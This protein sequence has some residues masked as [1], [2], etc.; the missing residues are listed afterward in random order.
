MFS[1]NENLRLESHL[2]GNATKYIK[3]ISVANIKKILSIEALCITKILS[4][5]NTRLKNA[6]RLKD[7]YNLSTVILLLILNKINKIIKNDI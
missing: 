2:L 1:K 7:T 3:P 6:K 5:K 4:T